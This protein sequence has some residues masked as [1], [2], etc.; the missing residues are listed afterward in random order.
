MPHRPA[1]RVLT[2]ISAVGAIGAIM[3]GPA[4][5]GKVDIAL[6][7]STGTIDFGAVQLGQ[8]KSVE[9]TVSSTT[10][11]PVPELTGPPVPVG[12]DAADFSVAA[13]TCVKDF[14]LSTTQTCTSTVTF[15]P[16]TPGPLASTVRV[17]AQFLAYGS[18][19]GP[20]CIYPAG[21]AAPM[22]CELGVD[23]SG[24][25]VAAPDAAP[26]TTPARTPVVSAALGPR[27]RIIAASRA[28]TV[29]LRASNAGAI[30]LSNVVTT[31]PIPKGFTVTRRG[32]GTIA[33]RT[34]SW[35][36]PTMAVGQSASYAFV[37]GPLGTRAR[38]T[39][40]TST[41][42]AAGAADATARGTI[43]VRATPRRVIA[44]TG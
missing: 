5:A 34:I 16:R 4:S 41:V 8:V 9:F 7:S 14:A 11:T 24:T 26:V 6:V 22:T 21:F 36:A 13:G 38:T 29:T 44:V 43:R 30:P 32:G 33:G 3:A 2:A 18:V 23:I 15:A 31:M 27:S 12:G 10:T 28:A 19:V 1:V 25:A 17:H 35:S 37:L 20:G 39:T 42:S 40:I